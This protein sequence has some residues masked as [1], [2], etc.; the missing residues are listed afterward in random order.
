MVRIDENIQSAGVSQ[1]EKIF[2]TKDDE[3]E[4]QFWARKEEIRRIA[5]RCL[6]KKDKSGN[7]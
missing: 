7:H 1:K 2:Y 6:T 3:T 5:V 4:E